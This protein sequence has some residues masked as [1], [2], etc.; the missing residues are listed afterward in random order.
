MVITPT[1][2]GEPLLTA[3]AYYFIERLE[4]VARVRF[5][6]PKD[7]PSVESYEQLMKHIEY[8]IDNYLFAYTMKHPESMVTSKIT[9]YVY[10]QDNPHYHYFERDWRLTECLALDTLNDETTQQCTDE[11]H[12]TKDSWEDWLL[13]NCYF[14]PIHEEYRRQIDEAMK[15][16]VYVRTKE[17]DS[18]GIGEIRLPII[19]THS[20]PLSLE[21]TRMFEVVEPDQK[22]IVNGYYQVSRGLPS[23]NNFSIPYEEIKTDAYHNP[24]LLSYLFCALRDHSPVSQFKNLYNVLEYFFEDATRTLGIVAKTE[25]EQLEA[26]IRCS[27]TSAEL[28]STIDAVGTDYQS[29]SNFPYMTSS[30]QTIPS[31]DLT[32]RDII[33]SYSNRLYAIRNA[34]VHSKRTKGNKTATRIVP[35]TK[36]EQIVANEVPMVQWIVIYC[37]RNEDIFAKSGR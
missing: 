30:G 5:E 4:C 23:P 10:W 15:R 11:Q 13:F 27:V 20:K 8:V 21:Q 7:M 9:E 19:K 22:N 35:A 25:K 29:L 3:Q 1:L 26:V 18:L 12:E 17:H 16:E 33:K 37:I 31:L 32:S 24:D 34:C 2:L 6:S 36:D 14:R 28:N